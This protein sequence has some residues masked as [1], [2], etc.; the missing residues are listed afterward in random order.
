MTTDD[1]GRPRL[2]HP[3][4]GHTSGWRPWGGERMI[5]QEATYRSHTISSASAHLRVTRHRQ[6]RSNQGK[7]ALSKIQAKR[8]NNTVTNDIPKLAKIS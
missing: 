7:R 4:Q 3:G 2:W 5:N 1:D 8:V 6:S